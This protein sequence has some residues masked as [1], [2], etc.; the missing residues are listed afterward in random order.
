ME[1]HA[2]TSLVQIVVLLML[3][4]VVGGIGAVIALVVSG[5]KRDRDAR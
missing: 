2:G 5:R 3:L 1:V 4:A